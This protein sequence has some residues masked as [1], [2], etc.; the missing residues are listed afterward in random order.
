MKN[1]KKLLS[2]YQEIFFAVIFVFLFFAILPL[3]DE[4]TA[5]PSMDWLFRLPIL[6]SVAFL[7]PALT[8]WVW[9]RTFIS[10]SQIRQQQRIPISMKKMIYLTYAATLLAIA[11]LAHALV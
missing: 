1:I 11:I 3:G 5:T 8:E 9:S 6:A 10:L 2:E 7:L 4:Y